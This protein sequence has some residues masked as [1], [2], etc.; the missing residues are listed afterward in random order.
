MKIGF[1]RT[2]LGLGNAGWLPRKEADM[3]AIHHIAHFGRTLARRLHAGLFVLV[4]VLLM[5]VAAFAQSPTPFYANKR[6]FNISFNSGRDVQ[7]VRLYMSTN[8]GATWD[9]YKTAGPSD[10]GFDVRVNHDGTFWFASQTAFN[11]G[12]YSP[13]TVAQLKVEQIVIV[14]SEPPQINLRSTAPEPLSGNEVKVGVQWEIRDDNLDLNSIRLEGRYVGQTFWTPIQNS[15]AGKALPA[16]GQDFWRLPQGQRMEVRLRAMDKANNPAEQMVTLG[17]NVGQM[18]GGTGFNEGGNING[19]TK[20]PDHSYVNKKT[21]TLEFEI[22]KRPPSGLEAIELWVTRNRQDWQKSPTENQVPPESA[23]KATVTYE[24]PADGLYGFMI[25]ARSKAKL[26]SG[27]P[28][29]G[30]EPSIWVEVDTEAPKI[31]R[32]DVHLGT[33]PDSRSLICEWKVTDKNLTRESIILEYAEDKDAQKWEE[34]AHDVD[35]NARDGTGRYV[36]A[37]PEGKPYQFYARIRAIDRAG[38]QEKKAFDKPIVFDFTRP[39]VEIKGVE[40]MK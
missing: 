25:V 40:P 7:M 37:K 23:Q 8:Q 11:N 2:L 30:A 38:N 17:S 31:D 19:Y 35:F 3:I 29:K 26:S 32:F 24:A 6:F 36:W 16:Q 15:P 10:R 28:T 21:I 18:T 4:A 14:D 9:V 27:E 39:E 22:K 33:G 5:P 1:V 12:N 20:G 34:I 13:A